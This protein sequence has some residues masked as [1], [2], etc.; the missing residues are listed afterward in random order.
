ML[1]TLT[2]W[3]MGTGI[4]LFGQTA[5]SET[6]YLLPDSYQLTQDQETN[7]VKL[8][9]T[10]NGYRAI[11]S[12]KPSYVAARNFL[13]AQYGSD[14]EN[15]DIVELPVNSQG[16]RY[17]HE[18][19]LGDLVLKKIE[20]LYFG[21]ELRVIL[22]FTSDLTTNQLQNLLSFNLVYGMA[23]A[24]VVCNG[25]TFHELCDQALPSLPAF[26]QFQLANRDQPRAKAS[27]DYL[28][29]TEYRNRLTMEQRVPS[30]TKFVLDALAQDELFDEDGICRASLNGYR[31]GICQIVRKL[32]PDKRSLVSAITLLAKKV[33]P[34]TIDDTF[35]SKIIVNPTLLGINE[36]IFPIEENPAFFGAS[37]GNHEGINLKLYKTLLDGP[38]VEINRS[39]FVLYMTQK[40]VYKINRRIIEYTEG[41]PNGPITSTITANDIR[42]TEFLRKIRDKVA[43]ISAPERFQ[44]DVPGYDASL[45]SPS[46]RTVI[47][48]LDT[49]IS[50]AGLLI[51]N[52]VLYDHP[53]DAL[54]GSAWNITGGPVGDLGL[55]NDRASFVWVR[56]GYKMVAL[57]AENFDKSQGLTLFYGTGPREGGQ[58]FSDGLLY[59]IMDAS[60][61]KQISSVICIPY[62]A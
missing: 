4:L 50:K 31:Q 62:S 27:E 47:A 1:K 20:N 56:Q 33:Y 42:F 38:T 54:L 59:K 55:W 10:S 26:N 32:S 48:Y 11:L 18:S 19:T 43:Y 29:L 44:W 15:L 23:D 7:A 40:Y 2:R 16:F 36:V 39:G 53:T 12:F 5:I 13:K 34:D 61:W 51:P 14:Y 9:P 49:Q 57:P 21:P 24:T 17:L 3:M 46:L 22:E 8:I 37:I 25:T 52:C 35:L 28:I 45:L 30:A 6:Q 41:T 58:S 60:Y